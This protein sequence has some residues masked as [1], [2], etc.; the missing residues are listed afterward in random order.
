MRARKAERCL[1]RAAA[2]LDEGSI[3]EA[4]DALDEARRLAPANPLIEELTAKLDLLKQPV[5]QG[6]SRGYGYLW[7]GAA[8]VAG[9]VVVTSIGWEGWVHRDQLALLLPKAH[10]QLDAST[11][12]ANPTAA[13]VPAG[14]TAASDS[15]APGVGPASSS[16]DMIVQTTLVRPEEVIDTR[17]LGSDSQAADEP[18]SVATAGNSREVETQVDATKTVLTPK[19]PEL[20]ARPQREPATSPAVDFRSSGALPVPQPAAV[21]NSMPSITSSAE[22]YRPANPASNGSPAP[23]SDAMPAVNTASVTSTP[24]PSAPVAPAAP[25]R[26][27]RLA[28]RTA[29]NRYEAAYNRLDVEA[30]HSVWPTLDQ[31][32]LARAFDSL[33]AQ[34]VSL[35]NCSVDVDGST[36]RA[37]CSGNAAWTPKIGGGERSAARKWMFDLNESDGA[38]RIVHVQAR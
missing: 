4:S 24:G 10:P 14:G 26:D 36:A 30:V 23:I 18:S 25:L 38:W 7:T 15:S 1:Q 22:T 32:A 27:E 13:G 29:L 31:R 28:I 20:L 5:P 9:L 2:A 33:T 35:Q 17:A 11:G 21:S 37:N 16:S 19:P 8:I 34:R 6:P 12:M 3:G